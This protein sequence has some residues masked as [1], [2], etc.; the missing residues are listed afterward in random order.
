MA[1]HSFLMG[2][3]FTCFSMQK[4]QTIGGVRLFSA[5]GAYISHIYVLL[6]PPSPSAPLSSSP[7]LLLLLLLPFIFTPAW[8]GLAEGD[9]GEVVGHDRLTVQQGGLGDGV[10]SPPT[11]KPLD[12]EIWTRHWWHEIGF[13]TCQVFVLN[14]TPLKCLSFVTFICALKA[15]A[16]I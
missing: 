8:S 3:A 6:I 4:S 9:G 15:G 2:F 16:S 1:W 11:V 7:V 12:D 5:D 10:W 13:R 14:I